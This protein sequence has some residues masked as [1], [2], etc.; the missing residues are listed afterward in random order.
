MCRLGAAFFSAYLCVAPENEFINN[1]GTFADGSFSFPLFGLG[2]CS[3]YLVS[4]K[5]CV[6]FFF[7]VIALSFTKNKIINLSNFDKFPCSTTPSCSS[8]ADPAAPR[9]SA[10]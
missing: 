2:F 5:V 7:F 1:F 10:T 8:A 4:G 9:R 3:A 6:E